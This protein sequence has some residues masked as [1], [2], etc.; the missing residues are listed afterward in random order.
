[1]LMVE[2]HKCL[3]VQLGISHEG[4]FPRD[5]VVC[6]LPSHQGNVFSNTV[7]QLALKQTFVISGRF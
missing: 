3:S 7:Y 2:E 5:K 4:L 1:M 6:Q